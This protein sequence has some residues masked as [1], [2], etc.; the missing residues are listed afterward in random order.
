MKHPQ[1]RFLLLIKTMDDSKPA[2]R[3]D[4]HDMDYSVI[5]DSI[6]IG[7]DLCKGGVCKIHGEE[8]KRLGVK[9][10]INLSLENNELPPKDGLGGY[11]WLPVTDGRPPSEKQLDVGSCI[12]NEMVGDGS[13]IYIHCKNGHGRSPTLVAAYLIRFEGK[14]AEEAEKIIKEKRPE[15]HIEENQKKVL[16]GYEE[17]WKK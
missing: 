4:G 9:F 7:S 5:T 17:K 1:I 6:F 2:G 12:I 15:I 10:E 16:G 11:T 13:K 3:N 8:F 14:T